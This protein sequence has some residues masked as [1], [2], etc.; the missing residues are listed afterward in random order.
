[1]SLESS[2]NAQPDSRQKNRM[3]RL[4]FLR[5]VAA[6]GAGMMIPGVLSA[7]NMQSQSSQSPQSLQSLQSPQSLQSL[8]SPQSLQSNKKPNIVFIFDDQLRRDAIGVFGGGFNMTT[9]NIDR[10]SSEGTNFRNS[11]SSCPLCTPFRGMLMTGRYPTHSGIIF[12]FVEA[13]PKQNPNCLANVFDKAGYDTAFIGKWH[14]ASGFRVGDGLYNFHPEAEKEWIKENPNHDFVPPGPERLGYKFWQAYNF[15]NDFKNYWYYEDTPQK[16]QTHKY[17]TDVQ[18]DQAIAFIEKHKDSENPFLLTIAPHPP[19]E[20]FREP[21]DGYLEKV[22]PPDNIKWDP[23]VPEDNPRSV[24]DV[25]GYYAMI[26]NLDDNMGRLMHYLDESGL[27]ENTILVFTSDHGEM[28]G[29]HGRLQKMVP[30]R[31]AVNIPL[32]I[33]WP[34]KVPESHFI[35]AIHTP[36]DYFPTLCGL[37]G[38]E[39]PKEVDG[40]DLSQVVLGNA[41]PKRK[42]VLI[43]NY[44][45]NW[46]FLQTG[47][48]WPEWRGVFTGRHTY[49]KWLTGEEELYDNAID[50]YQMKNIV[51]DQGAFLTLQNLRSRLRTLLEK[52]NDDFRP[53]NKYNEWFNEDRTLKKTGLGPV[54]GVR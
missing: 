21:P 14:L 6:G 54:P 19:H 25:R 23:N 13:S 35:D 27:S 48:N 50:P 49:V 45:S 1:M 46:D 4:K 18:F 17:E 11:V 29:S 40:A 7:K 52:A 31:E 28:N 16:I 39:I 43:A 22:V 53:G 51:H 32:I 36:M 33:R 20:P 3:S 8:Q 37:T 15:L 30:Y 2:K 47:T 5:N 26:K 42:D 10:L 24:E 38:V 34:G 9:P 44:T 41:F 12:N